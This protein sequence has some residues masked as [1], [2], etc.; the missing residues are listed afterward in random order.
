VSNPRSHAD[1]TPP[2]C[3]LHAA[4]PNTRALRLGRSL[5]LLTTATPEA[6]KFSE[7]F[8]YSLVASTR[9]LRL[10]WLARLI[11]N[12]RL[13]ESIAYV[14]A[15]VEKHVL[16]AKKLESQQKQQRHD[17]SSAPAASRKYVFLDE[18]IRSGAPDDY[19]RD[20]VLSIMLAGRDT[21]A[22][23]SSSLFYELSRRPDIV[24]K[25]RAEIE[26]LGEPNPGW[27]QLKGLKYLA[28]VIKECMWRLCLALT[29]AVFYLCYS[30][31][32]TSEA[33]PRV[34]SE[35]HEL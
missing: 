2:A 23:A 35:A 19:V 8:D 18:M 26:E 12:R 10:G 7:L 22:S 24:A 28:N 33:G 32:A 27:E 9:A 6:V 1:A 29:P 13:D 5:G 30:G 16:E 21:T 4:N 3:P 20:Q 15:Y 17:D 34:P 11:P 31:G 14:R 25:I